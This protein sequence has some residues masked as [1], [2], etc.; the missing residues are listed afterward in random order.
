VKPKFFA[1]QAAFREW[2][3]Q[4]H[5]RESE[6]LVGF[7]KK[8][9]GKPSITWPEAVEE[10]LCFGWID[11]VRRSVDD[12]SY[13]NRFTPRRP[14]STWSAVN[15][16]KAKALIAGGRMTPAGAR[17][18]ERGAD[19]RAAKSSY[20]QRHG[21]SLTDAQ[22]REFRKSRSAWAWFQAQPPSYQ[23]AAAYWVVSAKRDE[24]KQRRLATLIK[25]SAAG[26]RVPPLAR[27]TDAR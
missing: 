24:T 7:H 6:V 27:P 1:T 2:L 23:R 26:R 22:K 21:S 8:G 20:E 4:N 10:A 17:V 9:S 11:G 3:E 12:E 14:G 18:F 19:E 16:A 5:E 15:I 13:V 25:D